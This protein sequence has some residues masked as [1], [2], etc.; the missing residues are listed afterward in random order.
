M[1]Y[2]KWLHPLILF[3]F[4]ISTAHAAN[5]LFVKKTFTDQTKDIDYNIKGICHNRDTDIKSVTFKAT[6]NEYIL[7]IE[8]LTEINLKSFYREY[9]F[10]LDVDPAK[11]D[12]YQPYN[13]FSVAWPNMYA[14]YRIFMSIDANNYENQPITRVGLQDCHK[15]DCAEDQGMYPEYSIHSVIIGNKVVFSWPKGLIIPLDRAREFLLGITT[16]YQF[17]QC[18]GEDDSP[19]WGFPSHLIRMKKK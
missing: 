10:W 18:N 19:Q 7:T 12:G 14:D 16:Y 9:Y 15:S 13:P 2:T 1:D 5:N 3:V 8:M 4:S 17:A 6:E 11:K